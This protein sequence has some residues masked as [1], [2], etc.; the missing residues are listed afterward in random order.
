MGDQLL[1]KTSNMESLKSYITAIVAVAVIFGFSAFK[2]AEK[3]APPQSGWYELHITNDSSP[4]A[5]NNPA[6]QEIGDFYGPSTAPTGSCDPEQE[7]TKPC[8]VFLDMSEYTGP[9]EIEGLTVATV[10]DET[11]NAK[12]EPSD[13]S[14]DGYS[15]ELE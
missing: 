11:N 9:D 5:Y 1:L 3:F 12:R 2:V 6:N 10:T 7:I 4:T 15:R 8:A 14:P 13:N